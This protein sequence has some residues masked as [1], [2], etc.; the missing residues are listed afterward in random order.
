MDYPLRK[1]KAFMNFANTAYGYGKFIKSYTQKDILLICCQD[2]MIG[3]LIIG[4]MKDN[5]AV[6]VYNVRYPS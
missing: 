6:N 3:I 4:K 5:R 1:Y 2:C